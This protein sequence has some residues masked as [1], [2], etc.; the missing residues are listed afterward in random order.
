MWKLIIIFSIMLILIGIL[1]VTGF[2]IPKSVSTSSLIGELLFGGGLQ[3]FLYVQR[4]HRIIGYVLLGFSAIGLIIGVNLRGQKNNK[5]D[6]LKNNYKI[7]PY[8]AEKIKNEASIC[9][10]CGKNVAKIEFNEKE[11]ID[12]YIK[13]E[14]R[15][16]KD[17]KVNDNWICGKC[18]TLNAL[19][20]LYCQK[21]N[22]EHDIEE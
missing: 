1:F 21:C 8:C 19:Y 10:Y 9:R 3:R 22:N 12:K 5:K 7:C 18:G 11:N 20:L 15:G 4:E 13:T 17:V 16:E 6:Y 14:Y 2:F